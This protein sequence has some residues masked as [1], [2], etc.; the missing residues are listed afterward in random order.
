[1]RNSLL[2]AIWCL[3][4]PGALSAQN[5][6]VPQ[7]AGQ[8]GVAE[9]PLQITNAELG[10]WD[11]GTDDE[12]RWLVLD[13]TVTNTSSNELIVPVRTWRL[14]VADEDYSPQ[15]LADAPDGLFVSI[16]DDVVDVSDFVMSELK[17]P[18][19]QAARTWLTFSNIPAGTHVP[20][21][22][23]A[24]QPNETLKLNVDL[25]ALYAERLG[26]S[27][28]RLGPGKGL[29]LLQIKG[30]LGSI[31]VGTLADTF[32]TSIEQGL[33]RF[34][35]SLNQAA[36]PADV[37][38]LDWLRQVAR[39]S[40]LNEMYHHR[41]PSPPTHRITVY[42]VNPE[43]PG[44]SPDDATNDWWDRNIHNSLAS[45]VIAAIR[46]LCRQAPR[47]ALLQEI[48]SGHPLSRQAVLIGGAQ[49][50]ATG[51]LPLIVR[52]T[53]DESPGL[54]RA[55]V[56][57]LRHFGEDAAIETLT[58]LASANDSDLAKAAVE[59]LAASRYTVAHGQLAKLLKQNEPGLRG[60]V[61]AAMAQTPRPVW[62]EPLYRLASG[63]D[64]AVRAEVLSALTAVG[65]PGLPGLLRESL[66]DADASLS[67]AALTQ[68][69][70]RNDS[71]SEQLALQWTLRKLETEPPSPQVLSF[72]KRMRDARAI[73]LLMKHL[74]EPSKQRL[75]TIQT[76]LAIGDE[77]AA[78]ELGGRFKDLSGAERKFV[79]TAL[80]AVG[81]P[82]FRQLAGQIM[83]GKSSKLVDQVAELL[84]EE[85]SPWAV[86]LLST[87]MSNATKKKRFIPL[88]Q[89]LATI[90]LPQARTVLR[91]AAAPD[92]ERFR[93]AAK[94]ALEML[95]QNSPAMQFVIQGMSA[96]QD[97][98]NLTLALL[99]FEV[100]VE[101]DPELPY[102]R[103]ERGNMILRLPTVEEKRLQDA[104][105]DF[106][107]LLEIDPTDTFGHT[108]LSLVDVRLGQLE[109][110][111]ASSEKLRESHRQDPLYLYNMACIYGR[112]IE[113][114][115]SQ[116]NP[117][118]NREELISTYRQKA[119]DD[120]RSSIANGLDD[121]N[122]EWM[123]RDPDLKTI[124]NSPDFEKLFESGDLP[125]E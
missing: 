20:D 2:L 91:Q 114:L 29:T 51:D 59:S 92:A 14:N 80:H 113:S 15:P 42:M 27:V 81:S 96:Y 30:K 40:G 17:S 11:S 69:M 97:E 67:A 119:L 26:L 28:E 123:T 116:E 18:A 35:V 120:L 24:C 104:R 68:L 8:K 70:N 47:G 121:Y 84:S 83:T 74:G 57:A 93:G 75:T 76:I 108:G 54:R 6:G 78:E 9:S 19:G 41:F 10:A 33:S 38:V 45:A 25:N 88:C 61:L 94:Q 21:M 111:I 58:R 3:L 73:P 4:V 109:R 77:R 110:G 122:R 36:E 53:N 89:A 63:G 115:E 102:A 56:S 87:A 50:L 106:A 82:M 100:A 118:Q 39:S 7:A 16:G 49:K 44:E 13:V 1:M 95:Y 112:A 85:A 65:H 62:S 86:D 48:R 64:R 22:T 12:I 32:D 99:H 124:Q 55:A 101:V 79:I 71:E 46:P 31:N 34:V 72:L 60:R 105:T 90:G 117:P 5:D 66:R 103:Q 43:S 107:K 125:Q 52:L 37:E 23:L 98:D